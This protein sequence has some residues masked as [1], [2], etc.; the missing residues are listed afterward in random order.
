MAERPSAP[1]SPRRSAS[2]WDSTTGNIYIADA[3][4]GRVRKV[5]LRGI[6]S[7][8]AGGGN[9]RDDGVPATSAEI[10]VSALAVDFS[11]NL[12]IADGLTNRIRMVNPAGV[13]GGLQ[14]PAGVSLTVDNPNSTVRCK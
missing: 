14:S 5:T 4:N 10:G 3:G 2:R 1:R 12:Y 6:I 9:S 11:G 8:Y 13:I 7:T